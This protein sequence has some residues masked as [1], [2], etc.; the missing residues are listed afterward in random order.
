MRRMWATVPRHPRPI[1]DDAGSRANWIGFQ[2][3]SEQQRCGMRVA[4][5]AVRIL[6]GDAEVVAAVGKLAATNQ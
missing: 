4:Q 6:I 1:R 2:Q 5:R 3:P